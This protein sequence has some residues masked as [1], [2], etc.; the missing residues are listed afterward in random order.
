MCLYVNRV[1]DAEIEKKLKR[2]GKIRLWK[3]FWVAGEEKPS[4]LS[5]YRHKEYKA[6]WNKSSIRGK[7][8]RRSKASVVS[9]GVHVFTIEEDAK[10][11]AVFS[12]VFVKNSDL[13]TITKIAPKK[14]KSK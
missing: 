1:T 2:Y 14:K 3:C 7:H 4:L 13:A 8:R 5:F 12:K 6:G 9:L 10:R 11:H